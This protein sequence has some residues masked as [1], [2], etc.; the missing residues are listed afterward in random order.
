MEPCVSGFVRF[1]TQ[2]NSSEIANFIIAE[3]QQN[4]MRKFHILNPMT[5]GIY[6]DPA[7]QSDKFPCVS[8]LEAGKRAISTWII[9][10][11][12]DEA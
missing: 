8:Q 11:E 3:Y 7:R 1:Q 4:K 6:P 9:D 5:R 2:S 12:S 10:T